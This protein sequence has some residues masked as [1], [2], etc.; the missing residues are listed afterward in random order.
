MRLRGDVT[1][2]V[3]A[4]FDKARNVMCLFYPSEDVTYGDLLSALADIKMPCCCSPIHDRDIFT[5]L[6]VQR[7]VARHTDK[8]T[9]KIAQEAIDAG[10]PKEGQHKKPHVHVM[11]CAPGPQQPKWFQDTLAS[12]GIHVTYFEK[13]NSI[14]SMMRYFAH[15][16]NP[17]KAA[18]NA[19]D[20]HGFGGLDLS[21]L[22]KVSKVTNT[23]VLIETMEY[24]KE[25]HITSYHRLVDWAKE[26]GDIDTF[27]VVT[28]RSGFFTSYFSSQYEEKKRQKELEKRLSD[29]SE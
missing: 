10:L 4:D 21:P 22:S 7:W 11:I 9:G 28:G 26:T 6:D 24:A 8:N 29:M 1:M 15:L 16:D 25:H 23:F 3:Y 27:N 2:A 5:E 12:R 17:E 20:I 13:V 19:F 18:Y 14:S